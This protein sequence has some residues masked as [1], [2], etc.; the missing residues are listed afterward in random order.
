MPWIFFF[1]FLL[2]LNVSQNIK[3]GKTVQIATDV[4]FKTTKM[5]KSMEIREKKINILEK[6][7]FTLQ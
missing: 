7:L 4:M 1:F 6:S 5:R 3:T 2:I